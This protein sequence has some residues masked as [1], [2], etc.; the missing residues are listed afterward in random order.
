LRTSIAIG[1][2]DSD[3]AN[4]S[5]YNG[6]SLYP[7]AFAN[8]NQPIRLLDRQRFDTIFKSDARLTANFGAD[9]HSL[10]ARSRIRIAGDTL[11]ESILG[12]RVAIIARRFLLDCRGDAFARIKRGPG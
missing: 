8:C 12:R 2:S 10:P 4:D 1:R 6:D 11:S 9:E 7:V 3:L 5:L